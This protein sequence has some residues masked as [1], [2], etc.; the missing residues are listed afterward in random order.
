[1]PGANDRRM[2]QRLLSFVALCAL[3]LAAPAGAQ[4]LQP[5]HVATIPIDSGSQA[6]YAKDAGFFEKNGLDATVQPIPNGPA[7]IA[8]VVGGT[9]DV[10][11]SNLVSLEAAY[12]KGVPIVL[13]AAAGLYIDSAPTTLLMVDDSSTIKTGKDLDDK[14]IATNGL[15]NIGQ[16]A[17]AAW[18]DANGGDS[19]TVKFVEMP[20]PEMAGALAQHRIDAAII[21]EPTLSDAKATTRVLG[22]PYSAI[23]KEYLIGAWFASATWAKAHPD[24]VA[25]FAA[26]M[27]DTAVWANANPAKSAAI[28]AKYATIDPAVAAKMTRAKFAEALT[29]AL[30]QPT[31]DITAKYKGID[32][33]FPA[34]EMIYTPAR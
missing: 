30:V 6:F 21:A 13:I 31:I 8:G 7:I 17:P 5:I 12:K 20:F 1:L 23:G 16:Y 22:K 2:L 11:F 14:I 18:V 33:P 3:L 4:T 28:L 10:G 34:Q 19:S 24:L 27:H 25:K 9:I 26:A 29:P 32:A 15:K